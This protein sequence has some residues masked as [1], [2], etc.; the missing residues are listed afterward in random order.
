MNLAE[1]DVKKQ[2]LA[3]L[4][5]QAGV[6]GTARDGHYQ[7]SPGRAAVTLT[8]QCAESAVFPGPVVTPHL[9]LMKVRGST[10]RGRSRSHPL[11]LNEAQRFHDSAK[12]TGPPGTYKNV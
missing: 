5:K 2:H 6:R 7:L 9:L 12:V 10:L 8:R 4:G 3:A 1:G 11:L